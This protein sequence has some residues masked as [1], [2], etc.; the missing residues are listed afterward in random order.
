MLHFPQ[1]KLV[2]PTTIMGRNDVQRTTPCTN[3]SSG[4]EELFLGATKKNY[5][6]IY[7]LW[8]ISIVVLVENLC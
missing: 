3:C 2:S 8:L 1:K 6:S 5:N 7:I 4:W